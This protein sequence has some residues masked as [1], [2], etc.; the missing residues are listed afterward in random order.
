[1]YCPRCSK[2]A[3]AKPAKFCSGC[4]FALLGVQ[5]LLE[6]EGD[7][8]AVEKTLADQQS[9]RRTGIKRGLKSLLLGAGTG[10]VGYLFGLAKILLAGYLERFPNDPTAELLTPL[11][12]LG[13]ALLLICPI[14]LLFGLARIGYAF[15]R[16]KGNLLVSASA[17]SPLL[18]S[19]LAATDLPLSASPSGLSVTNPLKEPASVIEGTTELL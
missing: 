11:G 8:S 19:N 1:M 4:G 12:Y 7:W 13:V 3:P 9:S 16:E 15:L 18:P 17:P 6:K 10:I 14:F 5:Q 2:Q